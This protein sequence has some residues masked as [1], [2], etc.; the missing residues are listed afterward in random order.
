[1][2]CL[3][4]LH[5]MQTPLKQRLIFPLPDLCLVLFY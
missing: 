5:I 2:R 4:T 1:L 3:C